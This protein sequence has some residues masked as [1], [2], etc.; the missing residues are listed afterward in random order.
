MK[1]LETKLKVIELRAQGKSQNAIA[2]LVGVRRQTIANWLIDCEEEVANLKA[3]EVDALL[4]GFFVLAPFT[5]ILLSQEKHERIWAAC[6]LT[7]KA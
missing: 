6:G 2:E 7:C 1:D 4:I 5:Q 3:M